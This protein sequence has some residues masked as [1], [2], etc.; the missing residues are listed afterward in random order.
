MLPLKKY[1]I[2]RYDLSEDKS[3]QAWSAADEYLL[4][5]FNDM[6]NKPNNLVIYHDRF[7]FLGSHL[8]QEGPTLIVT[9]KSQ[10]KAINS[11]LKANYLGPLKFANPISSLEN[12]VDVALLKTP[13]SLGLFQLYLEQIVQYSSDEVTVVCAFMT[14][15][16]SSNIL[17]IAN[18]Y[19]EGVE[20]S[21]AVKKARLLVLTKKKKAVQQKL[22]HS[23]T[24]NQME[25]QQYLGVFSEGHI[26][27]ATQFFL[28]NIELEEKDQNILDLA[29]GNGIIGNEILKQQPDV[30]I[31]LMDDSFLAVE[32]AK[33]NVKGENV[34]HHFN[35]EL[36]IF[37]DET[38][39][40]IVSNP[41]FHFEH[42]IN[43]QVPLE[44][45]K[46]CCRC[47]KA[48]GKFQVVASR[49]LN[50]KTHLQRLFPQVEIIAEDKKFVIYR[51]MK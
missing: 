29:S 22:I 33:L 50:F 30:E 49:H 15:H 39:D 8:H 1:N 45:F 14:R 11:N 38:F 9:N 6:E 42:E 32:S 7:G 40:L 41:P 3:L 46:G 5:A 23:I 20:Q 37:A 28:E 19:F 17:E 47:L 34:H 24:Y 4:E 35:N 13:K 36:S 16:F 26:D 44:L 51:C 48:G 25:Y 27:Y 18:Q 10:E 21:K 2:K 31:H 12:Q 43:I